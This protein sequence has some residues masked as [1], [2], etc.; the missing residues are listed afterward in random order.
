MEGRRLQML[1]RARKE[2]VPWSFWEEGSPTD[3]LI[4]NFRPPELRGNKSVLFE[5]MKF[6]IIVAEVTGN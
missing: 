6:G 3:T 1:E 2:G 4:L 5:S